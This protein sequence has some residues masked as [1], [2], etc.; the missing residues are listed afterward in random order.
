MIRGSNKEGT[1][2]MNNIPENNQL[3][4]EQIEEYNDFPLQELPE[5]LKKA[6]LYVSFKNKIPYEMA[7]IS[8]IMACNTAN[9][10]RVE[11]NDPDLS[12]PDEIRIK[13]RP[14][15]LFSFIVARSGDRKS[16]C[17]DEFFN[18]YDIEQ[19][20]LHNKVMEDR[21]EYKI[22]M[23]RY[24]KQEKSNNKAP[25]TNN[26][27]LVSNIKDHRSD[28]EEPIEPKDP[29]LIIQDMNIDSY[30]KDLKNVS[31]DSNFQTSIKSDEGAS[32]LGGSRNKDDVV[33]F[34]QNFCAAFDR[35]PLV[36]SRVKENNSYITNYF[37]NIN[38]SIQPELF[39]KLI[40]EN[41]GMD[42]GG[43]LPR[44]LIVFPRSLAG[45]RF[46]NKGEKNPHLNENEPNP[47]DELQKKL[48]ICY[49]IRDKNEREVKPTLLKFSSQSIDY[50]RNEVYNKYE[51]FHNDSE[52]KISGSSFDR[53][54]SLVCRVAA[55]FHVM[56]NYNYRPCDLEKTEI[57]VETTESA[58]KIVEWVK[59]HEHKYL[60][61][62]RKNRTNK[63][64]EMKMINNDQL[65]KNVMKVLKD[66]ISNKDN[67]FKLTEK[68]T[69]VLSASSCKNY[70]FFKNNLT[71]E[72]KNRGEK[73]PL[74]LACDWAVDNE[75]ILRKGD[76]E[77]GIL[78]QFTE[79][80]YNIIKN[81]L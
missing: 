73:T 48:S 42:T 8:C 30:F 5:L 76:D 68:R 80:G 24:Q 15:S 2:H 28:I 33:K 56:K 41:E 27:S 61:S 47:L 7:A 20:K 4:Q 60:Y 65:S 45:T 57:D 29:T 6:V 55:T 32:V 10:S 13:K 23:K 70:R 12:N 44:F 14:I 72:E 67:N 52:Q 9:L 31:I 71:K 3:S 54:V 77:K 16:T 49:S 59:Q 81:G 38:L 58:A 66:V 18:F 34:T 69:F 78:F 50:I 51:N 22:L 79:T 35:K 1:S 17:D 64:E 26:F 21:A 11:Y 19:R 39:F 37:L 43:L 40:K 53:S 36:L 62:M 25:A 63:T 74:Q 46:I 75:F